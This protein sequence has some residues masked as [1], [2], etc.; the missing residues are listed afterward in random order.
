MD[1]YRRAI[2]I[3]FTIGLLAASGCDRN[4]GVLPKTADGQ[5]SEPS[6]G[7]KSAG[8]S[9]DERDAYAK[10]A[11]REIDDLQRALD[12]LEASAKQSSA[13]VRGKLEAKIHDFRENL[14][15]IEKKWRDLEGA[16]ADAWKDTKDS[17]NTAIRNLREAIQRETG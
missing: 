12:R 9:Q 5:Q 8:A 10:T 2:A 4:E 14:N 3:V 7:G 17:L 11:R 6:G 16:S 13:D 15:V 1:R